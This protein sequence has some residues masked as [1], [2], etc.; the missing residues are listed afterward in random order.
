MNFLQ[1]TQ[2]R[3]SPNF[4][5]DRGDHAHAGI[6][7][8]APAGTPVVAAAAGRVSAANYSSTAGNLVHI[9]H[10]GGVQT[11]YF[12]LQ[13]S[14]VGVGA[15]VAQGQLIGYVGSTGRSTGPHLHWE[16]RIN[17]QA[18]DPLQALR[19]GVNAG[20]GLPIQNNYLPSPSADSELLGIDGGTILLFL[21]GT[22]V[23]ALL[24]RR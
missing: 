8:A 22:V 13:R 1:P 12:H 21:F 9:E 10:G 11:R 3:I 2:G 6:D 16:V 23:L 19:N 24:V 5:Q 20:G 17:G 14:V 15:N 4:G 7:I 18:I